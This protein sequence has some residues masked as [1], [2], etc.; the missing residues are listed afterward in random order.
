MAILQLPDDADYLTYLQANP[1]ESRMLRQALLVSVTA[2]R[3]DP[4]AW[5]ALAAI[6]AE[7]WQ[8]R[9]PEEPLRIWVPGCATGEE[10]YPM[11]MLVHSGL[12]HADALASSVKIFATDL[13]DVALDFARHGRYPVQ[14][15]AGLP[16]EWQEP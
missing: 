12:P 7:R 11:D 13:D 10:A 15:I 16:R 5:D 9:S 2:F 6:L 8:E 14:A 1:S 3:R 4:A